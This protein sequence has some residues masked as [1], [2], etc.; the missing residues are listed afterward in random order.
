MSN[1]KSLNNQTDDLIIYTY[2]DEENNITEIK[3]TKTKESKQPNKKGGVG[4]F[5]KTGLILLV[6]CAI[7]GGGL[8]LVEAMTGGIIFDRE[9][10]IKKEAIMSVFIN[11]ETYESVDTTL[12]TSILGVYKVMDAN[13][14]VLGF[15]AHVVSKGFMDNIEMMVGVKLDNTISR[16]VVVYQAETPGLGSVIV[17]EEKFLVRFVNL[18]S[19]IVLGD[20][21]NAVTGATVS[22]RAVVEGLNL[23]INMVKSI[24]K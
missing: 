16:A 19:P 23:A 20:K 8:A 12:P 22:S 11:A 3:Q 9:E 4:G 7:V 6:I 21:V 17:E 10:A 14:Q 15:T 18:T 5:I 1:S 13:N 24:N 2:D